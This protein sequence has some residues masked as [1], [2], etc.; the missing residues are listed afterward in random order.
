MIRKRIARLQ[1]EREDPHAI[2][3]GSQA[4]HAQNDVGRG[5]SPALALRPAVAGAQTADAIECLKGPS[6]IVPAIPRLLKV[7]QHTRALL[8]RGKWS[9]ASRRV[10]PRE[11]AEEH[12]TE[13]VRIIAHNLAG[14]GF[15]GD[16]GE[17][18]GSTHFS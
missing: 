3:S 12:R 15:R 6:G 14:A 18:R 17:P 16:F 5:R 4:L 7:S 11:L 10:V 13:I 2:N 9:E 8:S 1:G